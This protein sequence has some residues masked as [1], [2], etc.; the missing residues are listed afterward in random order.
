MENANNKTGTLNPSDVVG[1]T[2][3]TKRQIKDILLGEIRWIEEA[4]GLD[5]KTIEKVLD[6]ASICEIR[7]EK[8]AHR[9]V[10]LRNRIREFEEVKE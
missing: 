2:E 10:N 1:E 9:F 3:T 7:T 6:Y 5:Y 8:D 4:S